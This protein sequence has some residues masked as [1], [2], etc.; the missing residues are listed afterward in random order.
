MGTCDIQSHRRLAS[1]QRKEQLQWHAIRSFRSG[2]FTIWNGNRSGPPPEQL[3][4][5]A[6]VQLSRGVYEVTPKAALEPG[7]YGFYYAGNAIAGDR[8]F[9]GT[10]AVFFGG[11][12]RV[13][14]FGVDAE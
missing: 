1:A 7:E 13:F 4:E 11:A 8:P 2:W 3:V 6:Y 14:A 10:G 12:G 9:V 5:L